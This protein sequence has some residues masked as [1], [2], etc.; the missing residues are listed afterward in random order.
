MTS[1]QV[2]LQYFNAAG[3]ADFPVEPA[4][5]DGIRYPEQ[6]FAGDGSSGLAGFPYTDLVWN[7]LLD[8]ADVTAL[9]AAC[10][11]SLTLLHE[12]PSAP[13]T[14]R[15]RD[16][17]DQ[18]VRVNARVLAPVSLRRSKLGWSNFTLRCTRLRTFQ[19]LT[20]TGWGESGGFGTPSVS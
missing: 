19:I 17:D 12:T 11:L 1:Y 16:N 10:G 5:P 8:R 2:A 3:L 20:A 4:Q 9:L 15:I 6:V 14:L 18:W 7:E 13:V